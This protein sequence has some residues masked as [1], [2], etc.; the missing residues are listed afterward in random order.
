MKHQQ[1]VCAAFILVCTLFLTWQGHL[2]LGLISVCLGHVYNLNVTK[3]LGKTLA[4]SSQKNLLA[5]LEPTPKLECKPKS[6]FSFV[7]C[8]LTC[9]PPYIADLEALSTCN[10]FYSMLG[11][12]Y[13]LVLKITEGKE[14]IMAISREKIMPRKVRSIAILNVNG[15]I[16]DTC[17]KFMAIPNGIRI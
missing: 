6:V 9:W 4:R 7:S 8:V 2:Y 14:T 15:H 10:I 12:L 13:L 1:E 5:Q 3:W 17:F 16:H 11:P